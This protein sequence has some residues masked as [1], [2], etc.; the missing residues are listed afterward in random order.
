[1]PWQLTLTRH[2]EPSALEVRK[3]LEKVEETD[4]EPAV[5]PI[6][7]DISGHLQQIPEIVGGFGNWISDVKKKQDRMQ[8]FAYIII[9]LQL[10]LLVSK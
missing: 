10:C 5:D 3:N 1:M 6:V 7:E 9:F 8:V 2:Q 4:T